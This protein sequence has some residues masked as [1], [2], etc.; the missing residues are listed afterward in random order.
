[1]KANYAVI[2]LVC[3]AATYSY[4][5]DEKEFTPSGK[6][7]GLM[8]G[9]YFYNIE[10]RDPARNDLNG[11]Q[12]RRIYFTYDYGIA[13]D[14][15]TRFRLE[16]DQSALT[17][18]GKI[19]VLVKDAYLK[20]KNILSGSD[21]TFGLSPNPA[22]EISEAAW[23][24]RSLEKTIMDLRNIVGSRD[25]GVDL[26]GAFNES[27]SVQYWV[28]VGNN[29]GTSPESNKFKRYYGNIFLKLTPEVQATL[30][31]DYD[32]RP[33]IPDVFEGTLKTNNRAT[34]AGFVNFAQENKTSIGAEVFYQTIQNS[35]SITG[36]EPNQNQG[37]FGLTVFAWYAVAK[38]FRFVGRFDSFDPHTDMSSDALSLYIFS[39]DY[40]P[41]SAV[42]IMPNVYFQKYE[43]EGDN[44][45]V[46]RITV[47]FSY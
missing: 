17:S 32:T 34:F 22:F 13:K 20:W 47:W 7:S 24:Y 29:S 40:M 44:D 42:H 43:F 45:V 2:A 5:Q 19:G 27:K 26:R 1:M 41:S 30:Y 25:I 14:F 36:L 46:G 37:V 4:A 3:L 21:L 31:A 23:G 35:P 11:F 9:E 6:F 39:L 16:A 18:N 10:Q 33:K 28:K 38:D 12:F 8:Y 15:S